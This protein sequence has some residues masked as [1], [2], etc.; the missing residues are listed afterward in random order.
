MDRKIAG[1]ATMRRGSCKVSKINSGGIESSS[2]YQ[3]SHQNES[4]DGD[5]V[6]PATTVR[7]QY[8]QSSQKCTISVSGVVFPLVSYQIFYCISGMQ[9]VRVKR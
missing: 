6:V 1:F 8:E 9:R 5:Q 3:T 7:K 4:S 2:G